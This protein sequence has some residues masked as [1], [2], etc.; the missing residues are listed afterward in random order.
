MSDVIQLLPDAIANQIAAGEVIQRP[1]SVVK[2]LMENAIDAGAKTVKLIIKDAG[3]TLIQ[4]VDDG[5]GMS[6]T[7]ARLCFE[8]HA[9]SKIREA[10]DLFSIRSMGF[11]GEAMAS[12]AAIAHVELKTCLKGEELGTKVTIEGSEIKQ[13][14]ACQCPEGTSI[15]VKNLFF[16]VPARRNF[17]KSNTVENRHIIEEF[18][19][20]TLA[21]PNIGFSMTNNGVETIRLKAENLRKRIVNVFGDKYNKHLIPIGEE[22]DILKISGFVGKPEFAR[23]T[24]GN[25]YFFV[26]DRFVKSP[27]FNHAVVKAYSNVLPSG[28]YPFYAIYIDIVPNR[29]DINVHPTKQEIEF[30]DKRLVYTF[31]MSAVKRGL[32]VN[33]MPSLDFDREP[34]FGDQYHSSPSNKGQMVGANPWIDSAKSDTS[35]KSGFVPP[36]KNDPVFD[37][38]NNR[39]SSKNWEELYKVLGN[40]NEKPAPKTSIEPETP[41]ESHTISIFSRQDEDGNIVDTEEPAARRLPYQIHNRYILSQIKSGFI[42]VDQQAAHERILFEKYLNSMRAEEP[43]TQKILFPLKLNLP[44]MDA[45]LLKE[46]LPDVNKM[47]YDLQEFGQNTFVIHGIPSYMTGG[48]ELSI[49]EGLLEQYKLSE[50]LQLTPQISI[51]RA[52]AMNTSIQGGKTLARP[53]MENLIDQLFACEKP[54]DALNG[55]QTIIKYKLDE[56]EKQFERKKRF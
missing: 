31:I 52:M 18:H 4:V 8:R 45:D 39:T 32:G 20:L 29:I 17:L 2:E 23:K 24:K 34:T 1:A 38:M 40:P 53:E 13:Q 42:L 19:R 6:E 22:T 3:R 37:R 10:K 30:E 28:S 44:P 16:N 21:N 54:Y 41:N 25:Q 51:A 43:S 7:D 14:E 50:E 46:L 49:I 12:I 55:R 26:N 15:S 35:N 56:I 48:D 36:V 27:Y 47:G 5:K 9:T 33:V 11:R